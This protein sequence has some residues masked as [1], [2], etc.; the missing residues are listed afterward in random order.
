MRIVKKPEVRIIE[1][2][3]AA[4]DLFLDLSYDKTTVSSIVQ[5]A[6]VAKGTFYH[7]FD[8]KE[9]I[10][11]AVVKSMVSEYTKQKLE[12]LT[13]DMNAI[14]K[15]RTLHFEGAPNEIP[16][17]FES[18]HKPGNILF[19]TKLAIEITR[20]LA[21]FTGEAIR[22]GVKEEVFNV[23]NPLETAELLIAGIQFLTEDGLDFWTQEELRR[24]YAS[25][26]NLMDR[27]L[28]AKEGTFSFINS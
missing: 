8:S 15:I 11:D 28:G 16:S 14:D 12:K 17:S 10:L 21:P 7:Y 18:I 5:K 3:K 1:L 4:E 25:L 24:R 26:P 9:Q 20:Q 23:Y 19:H 22:Q 6:N 13:C 27:C 2:E